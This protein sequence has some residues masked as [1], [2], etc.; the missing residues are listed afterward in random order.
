MTELRRSGGDAVCIDSLMS[1]TTGLSKFSHTLR[2]RL[3]FSSTLLLLDPVDGIVVRQLKEAR[4]WLTLQQFLDYAVWALLT[5]LGVLAVSRA[6]SPS[7][8]GSEVFGVAAIACPLVLACLAGFCRWRS[9]KSVA[10]ELDAR[11]HTKDRFLTALVLPKDKT[12]VL[13]DAARREAS[14][15]AANLRIREHLRPKPPWRKALWLVIPLAVLGLLEGLQEWRAARVAPELASAQKLLEQVRHAAERQAEADNEF[16]QIAEQLQDT[17]QQLSESSEPLREALRALAELEQRLSQ[18]PELS[19]AETTALAEALARDHAELAS[20]LRSG[21]NADSARA[22]AQLD[23]AELASALKQAARHLESRRLREL[24]NQEPAIAQLQLGM[25]LG[26]SR[27]RGYE[28][29][30]R[31]FLSALREMKT[32]TQGA[33]QD[34]AQ[35]GE[36]LDVAPGSEKSSAS[37]ADNS[38]PAG[39][40]GSEN[41]LGRGSELSN[42]AEPL[43]PPEGSED[44]VAGEIGEGAS[45]VELFHAAGGDDPK[46]RRTYRSAYQVAAPAALDALNQEQIPAGSRILVRRYFEA[47]RPKD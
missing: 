46:A 19:A 24:M 39:A 4:R 20:N 8:P 37:A 41:D 42:E 11:A 17:E 40:P 5:G 22:V 16:Q 2:Y 32:G 1:R 36:G 15:F 31:R 7:F 26:S 33:H 43:I 9:L 45:L 14:A 13:F 25:M 21:K 47:I 28:T 38:P 3:L 35:D 27:G 10:R 6:I 30:R 12:G 23:P 18:H 34:G 44:F 29:G